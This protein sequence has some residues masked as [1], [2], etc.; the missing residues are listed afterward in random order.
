M[1]I[2]Y[3][4]TPLCV[5]RSGIGTYTATLL[6]HLGRLPDDEIVPLCHRP[7]PGATPL[8]VRG[9][10]RLSRLNKTLWM[11]TML[12]WQLPGLQVDVCHFTNNVGPVW[13]PCPAVITIHDMT[14]WLFPEYHG[15]RRQLSMRPFIPLAARHAAA[16][17]TVSESA[18]QDI[19]R[20]LRVP[21]SKVHVIYEA[22]APCFRVLERGP[23]LEA[24][25]Q[26]H[27]LPERFILYVGT[28]EPRK[29]LVRLLEAFAQV[30]AAGERGC[31]LVFVGQRGWRDE[32]VFAAVERLELAEAVRFLGYTSTET[33]VAL[34]NLAEAVAFP[35]LYEGFGLPVVE[36]MVCGTPVVT[37]ATSSLGEIAGDAAELVDPTSVESIAAGLLR[38]LTDGDR[39]EELRARG[40]A[41]AASFSWVN[42]ALQTRQVYALAAAREARR[43]TPEPLA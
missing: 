9:V 31:Q 20:I 35:S 1:R 41:R 25:R 3:D 38:V 8:P 28:I 43:A 6:E 42:T 29:N 27:Q 36:A 7:L 2:G 33:V 40:L 22:P 24:V 10:T 15:R 19:V 16:I 34:Y 13:T 5:P 32:A 30:R 4:V 18:K 21:E 39:R 37:S 23:R 12:P 26:T 11:Q 17:I 14:L